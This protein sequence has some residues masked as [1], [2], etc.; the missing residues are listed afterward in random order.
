MSHAA[1]DTLIKS[2]AQAL[3]SYAMSVFKMSIGFCEE[4]EKLIRDFWWGDESGSRKVHWT[5]WENL[6]KPKGRGGM[7]FR[8]IHLFNQAMLARQ[9]WRLVNKPNSLCARVLK[10]K[11]Y[12]NGDILD[13]VF[14][15]DPS[16]V[17][18]VVE[19]GLDLLKKGII[20][21][22][23]D[24]KKTKIN[25]DQWIP[26]ESSLKVTVMKKNSRRRWV[27][28]LLIPGTKNWDINL[29]HELFHAY[30]AEAISNIRLPHQQSEDIVAWHYVPSS[31]K[32]QTPELKY[33]QQQK[34]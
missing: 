24:G 22:I 23:G 7:G 33:G 9:A 14:A 25:R 11:Y 2:V 31:S 1:K 29:L 34:H 19:F 27:N 6:T 8:D 15:S 26:R 12:P 28:Q 13:T 3:P 32:P 5:A 30:D 18:K 10:T 20:H 17:W 21:R 16:P 4:Y